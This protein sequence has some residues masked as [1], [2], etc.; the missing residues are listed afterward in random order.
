MRDNRTQY[1]I[2]F[3]SLLFLGLSGCGKPQQ[4]NVKDAVLVLSPVDTNPSALYFT[5]YGGPENVHLRSLLSTSVIRTELHKSGKNE[6]TGIMSMEKHNEVLI[7]ADS[8]IEFKR[9]SYHGMIWGVNL[10]ARRTAEIDVQFVFSN[11]DRIV[12]RAKV[13]ELD[14]S[15]PDE[16]K[17]LG[18]D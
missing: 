6:E 4:L 14:G 8:K 2:T 17:A 11:G 3:L 16:R 13:Q 12:A 9:G 5:V 1:I 10:I 7:P 15:A 18:L